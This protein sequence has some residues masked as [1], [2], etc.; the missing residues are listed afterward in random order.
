MLGT[1]AYCDGCADDFL[2]PL[3]YR[4]GLPIIER[5]APNHGDGWYWLR[6]HICDADWVGRRNDECAYCAIRIER[7]IADQ[8][9]ALLHPA[10]LDSGHA[11]AIWRE[12]LRHAIDSEVITESEAMQAKARQKR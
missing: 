4:H 9:Q 8:R 6:C 5:K 7:T 12:R 2:A 1:V 10:C 3:R 11:I